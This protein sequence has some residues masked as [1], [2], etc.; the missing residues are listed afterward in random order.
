MSRPLHRILIVGCG[1]IGERHIRTFLATG[2]CTVAACDT[3][4]TLLQQ[5][6][7]R[8]G[9]DTVTDWETALQTSAFTGVVIAT[10]APLHIAMTTL[11]LRHGKHVFIEKPLSVEEAGVD[12]LLA[13]HRESGRFVAVGYVWHCLPALRAARAFLQTGTFGPVRHVSV[14]TGQHFPT[15]RPAYRDI[16]YRDRAQGGG[17]I[18]DALTHMANTIE[19]MIG[20]TDRVFCDA[21]H[22]VLEGVEVE[23]TV[24]LI[25]HNGDA[26]VN[27]SLNQFQAPTETRWDFHAAGGSVRV[28]LH[29]QRWGTFAKG[30]AEWN[31]SPCPVENRDWLYQTQAADFLDGCEGVP[32]LLCTLEEG[33]D[34]L[35]FNIAAFR[36]WQEGRPVQLL[37]PA[38]VR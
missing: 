28:E 30:D 19:W 31:W 20:R 16:Y 23:D 10:P 37:A 24:N 18:Q 21:S 35:R 13:A 29:T 26:L 36:S 17:A 6:G 1:S 25:A 8:Y 27:Y 2:R 38:L 11:A 14:T 34:A 22:Q 15:F 3:R 12:S 7:E 5:M 9:I 33:L 4:P 32:T